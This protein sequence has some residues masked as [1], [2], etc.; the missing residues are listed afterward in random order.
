MSPF[1]SQLVP[2]A[3]DGDDWMNILFLVVVAVLYVVAGLVKK[4]KDRKITFDD[5]PQ[6]SA[7]RSSQRQP[8]RPKLRKA[9]AEPGP[10]RP[11]SLVNQ[12]RAGRALPARPKSAVQPAV[13]IQPQSP[14]VKSQ[15][16]AE[17]TKSIKDLKDHVK[18]EPM[19]LTKTVE[20]EVEDTSFVYEGLA[21]FATADDLRRAVIYYEVFGSPIALRQSQGPPGCNI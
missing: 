1:L 9:Q 3:R 18:L 15:L 14:Y 8:T 2:A 16:T 17:F 13:P 12:L 7:R 21:E 5:K 11:A 4:V 6:P 19:S 10:Q 20:F